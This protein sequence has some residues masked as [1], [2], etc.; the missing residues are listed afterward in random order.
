MT[1]YIDPG[2]GSMLFTILIGVIGAGFYSLRMLLIKL[3][4]RI[5]GGKA[6]VSNDKLPIVIF[7]DDKRYWTTFEP[8]CK[9]LDKRGVD[10]VYMT[11]SDNDPALD[12][13]YEHVK[14]EFI[15]TESKAFARLNFLSANI[16]LSTTP[17]LDVYQW[18]RSKE[19]DFYVHIPHAANDIT[20]YRMFGLD[21]Y[22]AVLLSGQYQVED[23]RAL[24]KLR[25]LPAKELLT[26]GIPYMDVMAERYLKAGPA[27]EHERTV[28]LAPSWGPS[29]IFS[30]YGGRI[31]E[32]LLKTG[33]HIIVRPHPQ[34]F[35]SEAE[36][37]EKLM[38]QYPASEQ[39]EWNRDNDNFEVLRRSD[40]LI[41]DFSGVIFDFSLVYD[42]P[43]IYTD[44]NFD[45]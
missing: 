34:S 22:D 28:L 10:V 41:S 2:T 36:L 26:V 29:A 15:G 20:L 1:L 4:F 5:S 16:L 30:V 43:I 23:I 6:E 11:A 38:K 37:M 18:K 19:V 31:I 9:E 44:P 17:S 32:V 7:S 14:A 12:N 3:R 21:Y 42:K 40:I 33:Y 27:P 25:S 35:S 39:L 13:P 45:L 8:I 24:E